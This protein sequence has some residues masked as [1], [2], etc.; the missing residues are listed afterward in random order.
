MEYELI[1]FFRSHEPRLLLVVAL[2]CA[3]NRVGDIYRR[4]VGFLAV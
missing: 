3:S 2:S 4:A 1:R